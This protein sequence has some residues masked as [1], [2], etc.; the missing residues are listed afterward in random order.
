MLVEDNTDPANLGTKQL[1]ATAKLVVT[2]PDPAVMDATKALAAAKTALAN[3][4]TSYTQNLP[5]DQQN[6]AY[7]SIQIDDLNLQIAAQ[8][9]ILAQRKSVLD[10]WLEK[11]RLALA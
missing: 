4:I 9:S 1:L 7:L 2:N 6:V 10:M 5:F 11:I 8:T 3:A